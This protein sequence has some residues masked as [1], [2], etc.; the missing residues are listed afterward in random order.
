MSSVPD[1]DATTFSSILNRLRREIFDLPIIGNVARGLFVEAMI[2]DLLEPE[3]NWVGKDWA[4]WDFEHSETWAT[5]EVKQSAALQPWSAA[6]GTKAKPRFDVAHRSGYWFQQN[7]DS[8]IEWAEERCRP[9]DAYIFAWHGVDDTNF[10][11][12]RKVEQWTF[13]I[14]DTDRL[15]SENK[16]VGLAWLRTCAVQCSYDELQKTVKAV[17]AVISPRQRQ[18]CT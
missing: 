3:W 4:S 11:D 14:V 13:Y 10:A 15:P 1:R 2:A 8:P 9:G 12:H 6:R 18:L 5:I 17:A 16:T 7:D